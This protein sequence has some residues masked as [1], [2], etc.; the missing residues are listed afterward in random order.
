MFISSTLTS[1]LVALTHTA[2]EITQGNLEARAKISSL[3]EIGTLGNALNTM[4]D[5]L[6]DNIQSLE[7]RVKERTSEL[8]E[9]SQKADRR[10]AQFEGIVLI[11][12]AINSIHEM[13]H[14][15]PRSQP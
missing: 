6:K 12:K 11:V 14:S 10:A 4:T 3:N 5:T 9:V 1:P 13:E 8:E 15:C 7:E 2:Q